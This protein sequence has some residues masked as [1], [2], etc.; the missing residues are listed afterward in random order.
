MAKEEDGGCFS[1][2]RLL[3]RSTFLE[4]PLDRAFRNGWN[5]EP[6]SSC[7]K[8]DVDKL[9]YYFTRVYSRVSC[10]LKLLCEVLFWSK[11]LIGVLSTRSVS[12]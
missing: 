12:F 8:R 10:C 3:F 1:Q 5:K 6:F 4:A 2:K 11:K 7:F 9:Y